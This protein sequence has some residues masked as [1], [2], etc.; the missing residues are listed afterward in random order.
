MPGGSGAMFQLAVKGKEDIN[1]YGT[2]D[3]TPF[4][5]V[6]KKYSHFSMQD[7]NIPFNSTVNFGKNCNITIP[8]LGDLIGNTIFINIKFPKVKISYKNTIDIEILNLR[9]SD[10]TVIEKIN[11]T[12]TFKQFILNM[13][14]INHVFTNYKDISKINNVFG[15]VNLYNNF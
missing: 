5:S 9:N 11:N 15:V 13:V 1:I 3:L 12:N 7:H 4:T 14:D 2:K 8:N 10:G 6:Y